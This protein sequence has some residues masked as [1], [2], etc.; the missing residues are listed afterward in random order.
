MTAAS[1]PVRLATIPSDCR[2]VINSDRRI[3]IYCCGFPNL[4]LS[5]FGTRVTGAALFAGRGRATS[6]D[7]CLQSP[8]HCCHAVTYALDKAF[9]YTHARDH[10]YI[11]QRQHTPV[12]VGSLVLVD[13]IRFTV[14]DACLLLVTVVSSLQFSCSCSYSYR[15]NFQ[16]LLQQFYLQLVKVKT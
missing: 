13:W 8:R 16:L 5:L 10:P 6:R 3:C 4:S 12:A 9:I 14:S 15:Y 11:P 7:R 1:R 2:V